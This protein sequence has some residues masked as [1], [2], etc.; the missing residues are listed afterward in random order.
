MALMV[1]TAACTLMLS[2]FAQASTTA[3]PRA[4]AAGGA[5]SLT[6]GKP[7]S[8]CEVTRSGRVADCQ[9][10]VAK[11]DLPAGARNNATV[12][13]AVQG[14]ASLVDARTWTTAGGNTFPGADVP[15][16]MV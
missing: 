1:M 13:Q 14:L 16:G 5:K 12:S 6:A 2:G 15:F 10:P 3:N 8:T 9:K 7:G 4:S 11:G